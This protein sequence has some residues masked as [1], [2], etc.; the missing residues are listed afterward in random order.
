MAADRM[1]SGVK[2]R[3]SDN[4]R[5]W[6]LQQPASAHCIKLVMARSASRDSAAVGGSLQVMSAVTCDLQG[7]ELLSGLGSAHG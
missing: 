2:A 7:H 5:L 3:K 4:V 1:V 6:S